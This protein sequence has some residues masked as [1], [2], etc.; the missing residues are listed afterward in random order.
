[1]CAVRMRK[2]I[3]LRRHKGWWDLT[4]PSC[5]C[6]RPGKSD[7]RIFLIFPI[8]VPVFGVQERRGEPGEAREMLGNAGKRPRAL[9]R[10]LGRALESSRELWEAS[11]SSGEL[12]R[13][14]GSSGEPLELI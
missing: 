4:G 10:A 11:E 8:F 9:G 5:R 2:P 6:R 3:K 14:L 1:M 12:W 13:A 7:F